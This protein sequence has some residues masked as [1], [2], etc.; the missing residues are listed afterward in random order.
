MNIALTQGSSVEE[1]LKTTSSVGQARKEYNPAV[2]DLVELQ[3]TKERLNQENTSDMLTWV[4]LPLGGQ[5]W[6][7]QR[8]TDP[9]YGGDVLD[10]QL[11]KMATMAPGIEQIW[12]ITESWPSLTKILL[13]ER[14]ND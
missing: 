3:K 11:D 14:N 12:K 13:E 5:E 10:M 7:P 8:L 4:I 9:L 1:A 6:L 2:L